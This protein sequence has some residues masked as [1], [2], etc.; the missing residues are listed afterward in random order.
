MITTP[1]CFW[2]DLN[3]LFW[4]TTTGLPSPVQQCVSECVLPPRMEPIKNLP[5]A[6]IWVCVKV[7]V[8]APS[9][10]TPHTL[11]SP[12]SPTIQMWTY[13]EGV[14]MCVGQCCDFICA[15]VYDWRW[16]VCALGLRGSFRMTDVL[17]AVLRDTWDRR[18]I[19]WIPSVKYKSLSHTHTHALTQTQKVTHKHHWGT[20]TA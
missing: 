17:W 5:Q 15:V 9:L 8:T 20:W 19:R 7:L 12:S 16:W 3:L 6:Y 18:W 4:H 10:L 14:C 2:C 1:F 13:M 11:L